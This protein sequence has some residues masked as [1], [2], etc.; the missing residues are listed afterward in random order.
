MARPSAATPLTC[1]PW[2]IRAARP[3]GIWSSAASSSTDPVNLIRTPDRGTF[4][5]GLV[6][7]TTPSAD[8]RTVRN[9][10]RYGSVPSVPAGARRGD[11]M[12]A[13]LVLK[14]GDQDSEESNGV[15]K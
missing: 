10:A 15:Y 11:E 1:A 14:E 3:R 9:A 7:R 8:A 12:A 4:D 5:T 13:W 2:A 6:V